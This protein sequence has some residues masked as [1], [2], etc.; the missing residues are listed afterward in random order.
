MIVPLERL[1]ME[2]STN[3]YNTAPCLANRDCYALLQAKISK[4]GSLP[5]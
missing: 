3:A 2:T 5:Q 4:S 1:S